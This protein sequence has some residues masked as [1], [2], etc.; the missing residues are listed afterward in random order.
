M[1]YYFEGGID[2]R[3][4]AKRLL[5][6][7]AAVLLLSGCSMRTV[8]QMY[9]LPKRSDE[10]NNLQSAIDEA[11]VGLEYCAPLSGEYQQPV[12]L[13]DLDGDGVNEYLLYAKG[14]M[15][16]PLRILIFRYTSGA[17]QHVDTI[18][19]N[20]SAFDQVEYAQMD[21]RAGVEIIVGSQLSDQVIRSLSVHT[22]ANGQAEQLMSTNYTKFLSVNLD[23]EGTTELFV[24]RPGLADADNGVAELYEI[25]NGTM[26][27]S[28]EVN[29]S[30]PAERLKRIV[31]GRLYGGTPA[32]YVASA[33]GD[34]AII[35]D[36]Y[37]VVDNKLSNI[38]FSNESGTSVQTLRNYYVY[39]DD[40]DN[41]GVV[42]L[43]YLITMTPLSQ[44]E[45]TDR[46]ELIRWYAMTVNGDEV[47]KMYTYH[48]FVGG[49]YI[50]L[51]DRLATSLSVLDL[52]HSYEFHVWDD[53]YETSEKILTIHALSGQKREEQ[54][55]Q[56][57]RT[58]LLKTESVIYAA[59]FE[60]SMDRY[61]ITQKE[62]IEGFHLIQMDWKTGET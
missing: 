55:I 13:A 57:D 36:I 39:A 22:F 12:Q 9:C 11:M 42:E 54:S 49:W 59:D 8:D 46:H 41:D 60:K 20:G 48:N 30:Q 40:I 24:L 38:S 45:S 43:P 37:A 18:E 1:L 4:N 31:S 10:Y 29:M 56:D 50:E 25:R 34:T 51:D 6:L 19:S 52:G 7:L 33:V 47:D 53:A 35:T 27:R 21:D 23:G 62:I 16:R 2:M 58:V 32:V 17:Y 15:E 44:T 3:T 61:G 14:T 26:E 28:N 5:F